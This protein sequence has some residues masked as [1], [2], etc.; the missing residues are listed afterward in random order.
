MR[1]QEW[2]SFDLSTTGIQTHAFSANNLNDPRLALGGHQPIGYDQWAAFYKFYNVVSAVATCEIGANSAEA[3]T[4]QFAL[5]YAACLTDVSHASDSI[6][7]WLVLCENGGT[8]FDMMAAS[9]Y[10]IKEHKHRLHYQCKPFWNVDSVKD[11][12]DRFGA[13]F[14]TAPIE[15][16]LFNFSVFQ[17]GG[18]TSDRILSALV[19]IEYLVVVGDKNDLPQST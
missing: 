1:Y 8:V 7:A 9:S 10:G 6:S 5:V 19:T 14:G 15:D 11:N 3:V 4:E 13:L 16:A 12:T 2:I 18:G 17:P